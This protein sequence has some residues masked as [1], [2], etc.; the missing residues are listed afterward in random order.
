MEQIM[1][2]SKPDTKKTPLVSSRDPHTLPYDHL[3]FVVKKNQ[4]D[5][6]YYKD[7]D[8]ESHKIIVK[9]C[10]DNGWTL[11]YGDIIKIA[12]KNYLSGLLIPDWDTFPAPDEH[13]DKSAIKKSE[14]NLVCP[15]CKKRCSST[16]GLTLH[17]KNRH[18]DRL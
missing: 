6:I 5:R 15:Y 3:G 17:K 18:A 7:L 1:K 8:K 2:R 14:D 12:E 10:K 9:E 4:K 16:S 11:W 13:L